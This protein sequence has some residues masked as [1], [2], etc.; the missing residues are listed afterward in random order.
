MMIPLQ[1]ST[2]DDF[3]GFKVVQDSFPPQY[4]N[5]HLTDTQSNAS[6][7]K[8]RSSEITHLI[9]GNHVVETPQQFMHV[10]FPV[11]AAVV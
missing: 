2:N 4:G 9:L 10:Q 8:V 3:H 11:A 7:I 5:L 6:V 1:I